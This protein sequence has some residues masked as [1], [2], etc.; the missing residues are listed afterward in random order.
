MVH[1]L[2][3]SLGS[4]L[5]KP[6]PRRTHPTRS[7]NH[8]QLIY[9]Q[10][11]C[12]CDGGIKDGDVCRCPCE[13]SGEINALHL[14]FKARVLHFTDEFREL[15]EHW[16]DG[17]A[18]KS[19]T[20]RTSLQVQTEAHGVRCSDSSGQDFPQNEVSLRSSFFFHVLSDSCL[21]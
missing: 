21:T 5:S 2:F 3:R 9:V 19:Q 6:P 10:A 20:V 17:G 16:V 8:H 14:D 12:S 4:S 11:K 13:D 18:S 15:S 1:P 7:Q